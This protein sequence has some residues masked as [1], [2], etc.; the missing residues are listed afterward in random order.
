MITMP[1]KRG[2]LYIL[3]PGNIKRLKQGKPLK[4]GDSLLVFTP[5]MQAFCKE[6]VVDIDVNSVAIGNKIVKG[7]LHITPE[8][9]QAALDK[10]QKLPEIDR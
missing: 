7:D 6:L 4:L 5:D 8:Q 3:E 10:C 2:S 9:L 1:L